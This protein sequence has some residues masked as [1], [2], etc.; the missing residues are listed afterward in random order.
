MGELSRVAGLLE[1]VNGR[2]FITVVPFFIAYI[3]LIPAT[4]IEI[5]VLYRGYE[6]VSRLESVQSEA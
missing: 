3:N 2:L 4:V 1:I 5:L 6:Y